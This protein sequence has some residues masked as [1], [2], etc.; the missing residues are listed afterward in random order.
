VD[1]GRPA[2]ATPVVILGEGREAEPL[3]IT[4][5]TILGPRR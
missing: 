2:A 5:V 4:H 3:R 1:L